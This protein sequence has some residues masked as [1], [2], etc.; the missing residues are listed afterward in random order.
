[1]G[2]NYNKTDQK[3]VIICSKKEDFKSVKNEKSRILCIMHRK[4]NTGVVIEY[5]FV[6]ICRAVG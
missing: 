4:L 3:K 6:G 2:G 1:M 5:I